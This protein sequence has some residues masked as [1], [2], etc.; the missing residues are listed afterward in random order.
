MTLNELLEDR[1]ITL[2]EDSDGFVKIQ[3]IF[4]A[5]D[6]ELTSR[7]LQDLAERQVISLMDDFKGYLKIEAFHDGMSV[8][9]T[10]I[11]GGLYDISAYHKTIE[12]GLNYS[13]SVGYKMVN[14][15]TVPTF[16]ISTRKNILPEKV[17]DTVKEHFPIEAK[18]YDDAKEAHNKHLTIYGMRLNARLCNHSP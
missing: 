6:S 7:A 2:T 17:E 18:R 8:N 3:G 15:R 1:S 5:G 13:V 16:E 12:D 14:G 9:H 11:S 10:R 4:V